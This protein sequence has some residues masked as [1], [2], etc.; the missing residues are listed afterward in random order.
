MGFDELIQRHLN[1]YIFKTMV[2][3]R[4]FLKGK[5]IESELHDRLH[6]D[7]ALIR[8]FKKYAALQKESQNM[9]EDAWCAMAED[10]YSTAKQLDA[11]TWKCGGRPTEDQL[12]QCFTLSKPAQSMDEQWID[13]GEFIRCLLHFT[14]A[15]FR[16]QPDAKYQVMS[17][18]EKLDLVL[19]W[20]HKMDAQTGS[21]QIMSKRPS[22]RQFRSHSL[23]MIKQRRKESLSGFLGTD[24]VI[25]VLKPGRSSTTNVSPGS[26]GTTTNL[27]TI[28]YSDL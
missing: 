3:L 27:E 26:P 17:L 20:C 6:S 4:R 11:D 9:E 16:A 12:L 21:A 2:D 19:K 13:L 18:E 24:P 25:A 7:S 10:L 8:L 14:A 1:E 5:E 23:S 15:L 28:P 22:M